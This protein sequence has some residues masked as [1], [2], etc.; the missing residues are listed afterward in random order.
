MSLRVEGGRRSRSPDRLFLWQ[1]KATAKRESRD[2]QAPGHGAHTGVCG[3]LTLRRNLKETSSG[4]TCLR[5]VRQKARNGFQE[6][7]ECKEMMR[8]KKEVA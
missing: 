5:A 2:C 3:M 4:T 7:G 6:A 8:P 1:A